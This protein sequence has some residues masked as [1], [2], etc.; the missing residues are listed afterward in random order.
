MALVSP[1]TIWTFE[2]SVLVGVAALSIAYVWAWR[3]A[4]RPG[5]PHPPGYGRL[6]LFT[7]SMLCVLVA[8]I[9]PI[10]AWATD[11]LFIHMV[12]HV[13]LLDL[14]PVLLILSLTKGLMRPVTRR[15]LVIEQRAGFIGHP[16]FAVVLYVGMMG[17]WHIPAL[18]D[19]ALA[20]TDIH[21]LEHA[22]FSA[23]GTLYWWHLL[24]P[25]RARKHLK[26]M[27][28]IVYMSVTKFFVGVLGIILA[29][30]PHS[31]YPWYQHH[32][33]YWGLSARV[34]QNLAGVVMALEQS[35][36]MGV[37][38][39]YLVVKML[40]DTDKR[41][42]PTDEYGDAMASYRTALAAARERQTTERAQ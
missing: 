1:P 18:Y 34:D 13:L 19:Y 30:A 10:D 15:V 31:F 41:A 9:S 8:L 23:A 17:V 21:V 7:L 35:V 11:L 33:H 29:F 16:V 26:G 12:Q 3:R 24:S 40:S 6:T 42:K 39:V 4:R 37:A 32:V 20:H 22:C 28:M 25:I 2:P 36:I 5:M 38:L 27:Q 14:M